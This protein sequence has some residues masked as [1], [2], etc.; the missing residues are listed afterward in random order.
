MQKLSHKSEHFAAQE[1]AEERAPLSAASCGLKKAFHY[2]PRF[3]VDVFR[4]YGLGGCRAFSE[5]MMIVVG[6]VR[7]FFFF[8]SFFFFF[9]SP[10]LLLEPGYSNL[11]IKVNNRFNANMAHRDAV[12]RG[13]RSHLGEN[14]PLYNIR[15]CRIWRP[16]LIKIRR[17]CHFCFPF[18]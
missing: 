5:G 18:V 4:I 1:M 13:V 17:G 6:S 15:I 7:R 8:L 9:P 16:V 3:R 14:R 12:E 10:P 11:Q 2:A